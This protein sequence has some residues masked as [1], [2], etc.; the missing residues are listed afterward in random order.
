MV[1]ILG[2]LTQGARTAPPGT[3]IQQSPEKWGSLKTSG[4]Y[5]LQPCEGQK[6]KKD[7]KT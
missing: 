3:L 7:K 6:A 5:V 1:G 2:Q 4:T